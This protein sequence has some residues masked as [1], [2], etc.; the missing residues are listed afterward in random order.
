MGGERDEEAGFDIRF[1]AGLD[2]GA[3]RNLNTDFVCQG[4]G[5]DKTLSGKSSVPSS[6][7][8]LLSR[9]IPVRAS[10]PSFRSTISFKLRPNSPSM[11]AAS[12]VP[13]RKAE[14]ASLAEVRGNDLT[15]VMMLCCL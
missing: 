7:M 9:A 1:D 8:P 14:R 11:R 15:F 12:S 6:K 10:R 13:A 4:L 2:R 3:V 5:R